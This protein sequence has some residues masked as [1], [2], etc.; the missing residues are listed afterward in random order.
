MPRSE[1]LGTGAQTKATNDFRDTPAAYWWSSL[2]RAEN[3]MPRQFLTNV[4]ISFY[5]ILDTKRDAGHF[6]GP[7]CCRTCPG[8]GHFA[9]SQRCSDHKSLARCSFDH[10]TIIAEVHLL[11]KVDVLRKT[12]VHL[13]NCVHI[14]HRMVVRPM[15]CQNHW[16]KFGT[17]DSFVCW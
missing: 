8:G 15:V 1:A 7:S 3:K 9:T 5:L 11:L 14:G 10:C 12:C 17:A 16:T 4:L 13:A 6:I 2:L